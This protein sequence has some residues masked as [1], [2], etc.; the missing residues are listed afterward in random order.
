MEK[1][2]TMVS[3]PKNNEILDG[4]GHQV[5]TS[6]EKLTATGHLPLIRFHPYGNPCVK[7]VTI[8]CG[9][10]AVPGGGYIQINI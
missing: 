3:A 4:F 6:H 2:V 1:A 10:E 8:A 9:A 7:A 5:D